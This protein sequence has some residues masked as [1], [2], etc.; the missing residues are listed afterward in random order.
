M[1]EQRSARVVVG[2]SQSL[3]G[4]QALRYAVAEARRR[5]LP[6]HAVRA[7]RYDAAWRGPDAQWWREIANDALDYCYG[8]FEVAMGGVP[9]DLDVTVH[10]LQGTH[11]MVLSGVADDPRDLLVVGS[12]NA[13]RWLCWLVRSVVPR[14]VCPVTVVPPPEFAR[15]GA[16]ALTRRLLRAVD[17]QAATRR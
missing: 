9:D 7:W 4:L 1:G 8:A 10:A 2:V 13:P 16:A 6:L 15:D 5:E 3:A 14:V 17:E 12:H 11:D